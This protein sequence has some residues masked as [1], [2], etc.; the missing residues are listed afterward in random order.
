MFLWTMLYFLHQTKDVEIR[1]VLPH[2]EPES[3]Q[4]HGER[5]LDKDTGVA[6]IAI[7]RFVA[8]RLMFGSPNVRRMLTLTLTNSMH[9]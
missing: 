6:A 7:T 5:H 3:C 1:D 4:G 2:K 9:T 8:Y